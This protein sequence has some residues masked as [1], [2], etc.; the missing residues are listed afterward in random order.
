M[1]N[2]VTQELVNKCQSLLEDDFFKAFTDQSRLQVFFILMENGELTVNQ[3]SNL[4]NINQSNVSRHLTILKQVGITISR[5]NG[6]ET[7]YTID[8]QN[9]ANR[10]RLMT[11]II[12]QCCKINIQEEDHELTYSRDGEETLRQ[13]PATGRERLLRV[14]RGSTNK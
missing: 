1:S 8:Y 6:R 4:M 10:L 14:L 12:D 2:G 7:Y 13:D 9:I 3:V 5:R 11:N